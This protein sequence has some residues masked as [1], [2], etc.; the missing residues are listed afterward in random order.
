LTQEVERLSHTSDSYLFHEHLEQT[1][2]PIY[3]HQFIER[4]ERAGLMYLSEALIGDMLSS[5]FQQPVA[6][7]LE[8]ISPDI[9]HLEQYMDFVRNRQFRQTLLCHAR[10]QP[11]RALTAS[12]LHGLLA[13]CRASCA[14]RGIDL[15]PGTPVSFEH[16][17]R[18][19]EVN[20]PATKAAIATLMEAWPRAIPV[21]VLCESTLAC[22]DICTTVESRRTLMVDLFQCFVSGL[23]ELHTYQPDRA[24]GLAFPR[25]NALAAHQAH[26][27]SVV[28]NPR[29]ETIRV[30]DLT[31]TVLQMADGTRTREEILEDLV[32]RAE[33]GGLTVA[34]GEQL[35]TGRERLRSVLSGML[36]NALIGLDRADLLVSSPAN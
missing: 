16:E 27:G 20:A 28:V 12:V 31:R 19:T 23:L 10:Q 7:T 13:A 33:I 34:E 29:H 3:F 6:E 21:D 9:V 24:S 17:G 1:N 5:Q 18:R 4:A 22:V 36:G 14:P 2:T 35:V 11:K 15:T 32:R 25:V 30:D 26:N 8:R